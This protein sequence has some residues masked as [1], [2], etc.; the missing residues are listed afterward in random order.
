MAWSGSVALPLA[1]QLIRQAQS[2]P[3]GCGSRALVEHVKLLSEAQRK[4]DRPPMLRS[5]PNHF[6]ND[7]TDAFE[8]LPLN[9]RPDW[10]M[11]QMPENPAD[12]SELH[13]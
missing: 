13:I 3:Y 11:I 7:S 6:G 2:L 9:C 10:E 4:H 12:E 5:K 8:R 1:Y